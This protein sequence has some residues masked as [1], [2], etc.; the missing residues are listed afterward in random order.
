LTD[1]IDIPAFSDISFNIGKGEFLAII[2]PS[3]AGKSSILKCIYRT[4]LP[5]S[6]H[7]FYLSRL[8]GLIDLVD[9]PER[10]IIN[11][12]AQEIGYVSQFLKVIPRVPALDVVAGRMLPLGYSVET[13]REQAGKL[14]T[15]L[16]IPEN[17][18]Y[19]YP[20]T[21]SG[22]EQQRIN[23]ARSFI[24]RPR[25][26]LLDEPTASLD[27]KTKSV[28]IEILKQMKGKGTTMIGIFHD[29]DTMGKL[30]DDVLDMSH[31]KI[32]MASTLAGGDML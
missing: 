18:W 25:L 32:N 22:G 1:D 27:E 28:V 16:Q 7:I 5:T 19:A 24:T 15:E 21:F 2:G 20:V 17:L 8:Y 4:Y 9:A 3:G 13:A 10:K 12:R 30:A 11:L 23:L 26:L 31:M 14:L 29:L 6:G